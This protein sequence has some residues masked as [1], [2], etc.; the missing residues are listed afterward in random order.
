MKGLIYLSAVI[1][2][3]FTGCQRSCGDVWEDTKTCTR[4]VGS[5]FQTLAGNRSISRQVK[6][7]SDFRGPN[8]GQFIPLSDEDLAQQ[9]D[10][11]GAHPQAS[12]SPGDPGS[13][14]PGIDG[15]STPSGSLASLFK[16]VHFDSDDYSITSSESRQSLSRVAEYLKTHPNTSLFVAGH[17]DQRGTAA[18]NLALGAK[19]ANSA[20]NFL[21]D[22]G[23][24]PERLFTISY[25]KEHL[26]APGMD[27]SSLQLNR[28]CEF[29]IY[30][31]G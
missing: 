10:L 3:L 7:A 14:L 1:A 24:D 21:I 30:Q 9:L 26:L 22:E 23:V 28:R 27:P 15:F 12:V 2:L 5:G 18:Y 11:D 25:G 16:N 4:Q 19:R 20:R 31:G 13:N 8:D 6:S 17:C 29:K